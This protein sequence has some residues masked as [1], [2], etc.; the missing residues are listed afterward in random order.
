V[1]IAQLLTS[2]FFNSTSLHK[3][4]KVRKSVRSVVVVV[5]RSGAAESANTS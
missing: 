1:Y 3:V 5:T 4:L 2:D